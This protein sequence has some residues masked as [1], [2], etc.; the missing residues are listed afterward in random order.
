MIIPYLNYS[1]EKSVLLDQCPHLARE[2]VDA[3]AGFALQTDSL[4]FLT[5]YH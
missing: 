1:G 5:S 2:K 3:K 4:C